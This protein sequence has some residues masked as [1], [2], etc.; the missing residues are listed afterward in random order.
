VQCDC[1]KHICE[2]NRQQYGWIGLFRVAIVHF[3]Y[4]PSGSGAVMQKSVDIVNET[5]NLA[6]LIVN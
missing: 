5:A 4:A 2:F 1:V 3:P 6:V